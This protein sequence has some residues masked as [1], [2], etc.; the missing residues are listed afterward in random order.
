MYKRL[1]V[2]D[3]GRRRVPVV[4]SF[5]GRV[6]PK[7]H[8]TGKSSPEQTAPAHD[9]GHQVGLLD[10]IGTDRVGF[11]IDEMGAAERLGAGFVPPQL[12]EA[13][14]IRRGTEA[15]RGR[16]WKTLTTYAVDSQ[17]FCGRRERQTQPRSKQIDQS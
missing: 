6:V 9:L 2:A 17:C 3:I 11:Y 5:H 7:R 15:G 10:Q 4:E 13:N 1:L 12:H 16:L 14:R 8:A